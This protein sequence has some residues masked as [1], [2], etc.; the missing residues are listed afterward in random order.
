VRFA[1][2]N[3]SKQEVFE[4]GDFDVDNLLERKIKALIDSVQPDNSL[5][6]LEEEEE[7]Y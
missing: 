4:K 2:E 7:S 1:G 3:L 5:E 6:A